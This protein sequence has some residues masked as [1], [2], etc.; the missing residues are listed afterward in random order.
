M[1]PAPTLC[2]W[3]QW[4]GHSSWETFVYLQIMCLQAKYLKPLPV[5]YLWI[6]V[7]WGMFELYWTDG[8]VYYVHV[9]TE[10]NTHTHTHN[11]HT[12][13]F[14]RAAYAY[15]V[16]NSLSRPVCLS[17]SLDVRKRAIIYSVSDR[18]N[19]HL[20]VFPGRELIPFISMPLRGSDWLIVYAGY[21]KAAR[22]CITRY[23]HRMTAAN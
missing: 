9:R 20:F 10:M 19:E 3:R 14:T 5:G 1:T 22:D 6:N 12:D 11:P 13:V 15:E 17:L 18:L 2:N 8:R 7:T 4:E 23:A 21:K 16:S